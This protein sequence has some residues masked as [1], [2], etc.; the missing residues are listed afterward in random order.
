MGVL[1]LAWSGMGQCTRSAFDP[2]D[3]AQLRQQGM[4]VCE[5]FAN[6]RSVCSCA[7]YQEHV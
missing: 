2:A 3:C 7:L 5:A 1:Q 4:P 6:A